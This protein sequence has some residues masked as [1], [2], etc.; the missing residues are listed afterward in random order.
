MAER[1]ILPDGLTL[2]FEDVPGVRSATIGVWLKIGSRHEQDRVSGICHFIEH[3]VFKGTVTRTARDISLL[4]DR[5]GGNIDAF[6]TK[7]ETCFYAR[8]LDEHIPLA[9]D[10]LSD[11]VR[12]PRFDAEDIERERKVI[13]EEIRMVQDSPDDRIYDLF[14][15]SFWPDHPLGRPIQGTEQTIGAMSRRTIQSW[16]R[17][18]YVPKNL[19]VAAAGHLTPK[20]KRLVREAFANL[21]DGTSPAN[22]RAPAWSPGIRHETRK[23]ME[24]VHLLL[25]MPGLP[26]GH[27]KRFTLHL[28]NTVLGGSISS[29]LF[30]RIREERGLAY[31]VA[32]QVHSHRGTGLLTVYAGTSPENAREVVRLTLAEM[33]SLAT[34]A[35]GADELEVARDHLKGNLLL[36]LESTSSRMSR[37]AREEMVL[38]RSMTTEEVVAELESVTPEH[39]RALGAQ[40]LTGVRPALAMV[41]R[42]GRARVR[43]EDLVL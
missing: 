19:L 14:C 38:G 36:S 6:T 33:A 10:L 16:F 17:R 21:P 23:Q 1:E 43:E 31:S 20:H 7:E 8:V 22:G 3:L 15:E 41:G 25:G 2:L 42:A 4:T 18:S 35:P 29:R 9:V 39:V 13:L 40:L 24:Q 5:I 30:R 27:E 28:L 32:S 37:A 34:E 11:I 26:S 12:H